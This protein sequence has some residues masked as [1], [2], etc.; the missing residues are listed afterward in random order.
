MAQCVKN[1]TSAAGLAVEVRFDVCLAQ[2]VKAFRA[3]I[4][5]AGF[6]PCP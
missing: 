4:A 6:K 2:C 5:A 1:P 3:A